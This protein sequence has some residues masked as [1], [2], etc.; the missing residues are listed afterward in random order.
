MH[1][2]NKYFLFLNK[3]PIVKYVIFNY[4]K[5]QGVIF[6]EPWIQ[7]KLIFFSNELD[8]CK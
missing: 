7:I 4:I 8:I 3:V 2:E 5:K 1:M 6:S